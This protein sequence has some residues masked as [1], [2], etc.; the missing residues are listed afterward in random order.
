MYRPDVWS[1]HIAE[2]GGRVDCANLGYR[3]LS[4]FIASHSL[5][6][7]FKKSL[8]VLG[9]KLYSGPVMLSQPSL[10]QEVAVRPKYHM[11]V[12]T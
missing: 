8:H 7:C 9:G 1:I 5:F 12:F 3:Y 4:F 11:E 6:V 2:G 10:L